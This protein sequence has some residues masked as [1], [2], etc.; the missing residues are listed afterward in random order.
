MILRQS[1]G[2]LSWISNNSLNT[3]GKISDWSATGFENCWFVLSLNLKTSMLLSLL[4]QPFA[5]HWSKKK[6]TM[7]MTGCSMLAGMHTHTR[8]KDDM[9]CDPLL[10]SCWSNRW[11]PSCTQSSKHTNVEIVAKHAPFS[12]A[13]CTSSQNQCAP[14]LAFTFS[15][16]ER[17]QKTNS[18]GVSKRY[19]TGSGLSALT[20]TLFTLFGHLVKVSVKV[21]S[22]FDWKKALAT[23]FVSWPSMISSAAVLHFDANNSVW[24]KSPHCQ[25]MTNSSLLSRMV[26]LSLVHIWMCLLTVQLSQSHAKQ[27]KTHPMV[28]PLSALLKSCLTN[29]TKLGRTKEPNTKVQARLTRRTWQEIKQLWNK[30]QWQQRLSKLLTMCCERGL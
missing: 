29:S 28:E 6:W 30:W 27:P 19:K 18:S 14:K 12:M 1:S 21:S 26:R 16:L 24:W 4:S 22:M 8:R 11:K 9:Q 25:M 3:G 20:L 13:H 10:S 7:R 15:L 2:H 17:K 5:S 23:V